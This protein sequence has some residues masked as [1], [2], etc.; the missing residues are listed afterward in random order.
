MIPIVCDF[1]LHKGLYMSVVLLYTKIR[2]HYTKDFVSLSN[3]VVFSRAP[4]D[5]ILS[6][7]QSN[8][9]GFTNCSR[10]YIIDFCDNR[11]FQFTEQIQKDK[12]A[13]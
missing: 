2:A 5:A 11:P 4:T 12:K 1:S 13:V 8:T 7:V 3:S 9:H 10:W 6:T